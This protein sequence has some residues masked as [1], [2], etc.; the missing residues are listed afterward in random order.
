MKKALPWLLLL[1]LVAWHGA[2][3]SRGLAADNRLVVIVHPGTRVQTL[4]ADELE[5]LFTLSQRAWPDGQPAIPFNFAPGA[6][7]REQFDRVVLGMN[8][9]EVA[10]FWI[11]RRIRGL[12]DAPRKVPSVALML[13]VV[14]KLPGALGYVPEDAVT[15]EVKVVA[16][17][18]D[19]KL[20]APNAR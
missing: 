13:R 20:L 19:G 4:S 12:G 18:V 3:A 11:D 7:L 15:H 5:A 9:D 17:I 8:G 14:A 16:R 6:P 2:I 1:V 10:R